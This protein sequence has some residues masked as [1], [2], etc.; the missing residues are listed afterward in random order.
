MNQAVQTHFVELEG[1]S[2]KFDLSNICNFNINKHI[3]I[4]GQKYTSITF[5][6]IAVLRTAT[7]LQNTYVY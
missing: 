2:I 3:K 6:L 7:E 1:L 4:I 5:F